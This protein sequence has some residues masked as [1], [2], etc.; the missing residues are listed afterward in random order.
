[1]N[2]KPFK[3]RS[4]D[5]FGRFDIPPEMQGYTFGGDDGN[6]PIGPFRIEYVL[7]SDF[8]I[9]LENLKP[10]NAAAGFSNVKLAGQISGKNLVKIPYH[11]AANKNNNFDANVILVNDATDGY[12]QRLVVTNL[13]ENI[14]DAIVVANYCV[15]VILDSI[16]FRKQTPLQIRNVIVYKANPESREAIRLYF[17]M[18]YY[19]VDLEEESDLLTSINI[20]DKLRPLLRLFREAI[21]STSPHYRLLCLYRIRERLDKINDA[22]AILLKSQG[23]APPHKQHVI[24]PDNSITRHFF[25]HLI[26]K[27]VGTF[28]DFVYKNYRVPIAHFNLDEYEKMLLDR[29]HSKTNHEIDVINSILVIVIPEMIKNEWDFMKQYGLT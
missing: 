11:N 4:K 5:K 24:V 21:N 14:D 1:M 27:K 10:F 15:S 20:P 28:L 29:G 18:P 7:C 26:G 8:M 3:L 25:P 9:Y 16:S 19:L 6:E 2:A 12:L 17:T 23:I 13:P 22:H